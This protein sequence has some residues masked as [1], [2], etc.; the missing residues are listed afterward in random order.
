VGTAETSL[1][2]VLNENGEKG[3]PPA[4]KNLLWNSTLLK[5][6]LMEKEMG[7]Q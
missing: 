7:Y 4:L 3:V 1:R 2:L 5:C 6:Y